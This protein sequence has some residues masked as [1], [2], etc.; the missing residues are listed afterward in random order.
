MLVAAVA[1]TM[2]QSKLW[3][4]RQQWPW[5]WRWQWQWQWQWPE[6]AM[7]MAMAIRMVDAVAMRYYL[8]EKPTACSS[9]IIGFSPLPPPPMSAL[10][11]ASIE[12]L[13]VSDV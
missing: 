6:K 7:A 13:F 2:A 12:S 3:A 10:S 9:S 5:Q 4:R 8:A 11:G 1:V